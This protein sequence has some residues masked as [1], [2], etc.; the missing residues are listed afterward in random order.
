MTISET[1]E[2]AEED[3]KEEYADDDDEEKSFNKKKWNVKSDPNHLPLSSWR[4]ASMISCFIWLISL[5]SSWISCFSASISV[6]VLVALLMLDTRFMDSL[7]DETFHFGGGAGGSLLLV[8]GG[9]L[10]GG[11]L[12]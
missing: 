1:V 12:G 2:M 6:E 10:L 8:I 7:L 3:E 9:A 5:R 11:G 4:M